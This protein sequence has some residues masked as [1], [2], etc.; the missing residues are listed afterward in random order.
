MYTQAGE[1]QLPAVR[2][3]ESLRDR[4]RTI[5]VVYL[6]DLVTKTM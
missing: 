2:G 6:F 3:Q 4:G 1:R 5:T